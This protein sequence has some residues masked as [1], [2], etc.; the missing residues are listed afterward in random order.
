MSSERLALFP[1]EL[2]LFPDM[3]LP[4]H[5]FEP[6]YKQMIQKCL[7]TS[8]GFGVVLSRS[9]GF[10][11]I[12]CTAKIVQVVRKYS[13]GRMDILTAGKTPFQVVE[14]FEDRLYLEG[15]V[16]YLEDEVRNAAELA[17]AQLMPL[18]EECHTL[19]FGQE[20]QF[21]PTEPSRLSYLIA[22]E[23]PFDLDYKQSILE[24][25]SEAGRQ[26]NLIERMT[27]WIP[28]LVYRDR[29]RRKSGGN[30]HGLGGMSQSK[31]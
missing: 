30:G 2:V 10:A 4:L 8:V 19:I 31:P 23:L 21:P 13:D 5:I 22:S 26:R 15:A 1:L 29:V 28:Q 17:T 16:E 12:G 7:E 18:Y 11:N 27:E 20:P 24:M 9:D 25:R 6:R 14:T 3:P